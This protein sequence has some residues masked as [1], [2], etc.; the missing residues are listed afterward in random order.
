MYKRQP[1]EK[2]FFNKELEKSSLEERWTNL[3]KDLNVCSQKGLVENF[4][5]TIGARTVLMPFG[6]KHRL[7]PSQ[8]LA[9]KEMCI[10]DRFI[11][12]GPGVI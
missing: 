4:D 10:R 2:G 1:S 6:G 5:S 9:I 8:G 12:I 3:L 11:A 7:T